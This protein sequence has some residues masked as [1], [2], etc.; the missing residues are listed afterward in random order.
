MPDTRTERIAIENRE[1]W[2]ALRR[3]DV[4]A[5]I[6][7]CLVGAHP[8]ATAYGLWASKTGRIP[9]DVEETAPMRRG[10]LLESVAVQ[11]L[12]EDKPEWNIGQH[13]VGFYYRDP[14]ARIGATPD[15][16]GTDEHGK[17]IVVQIKSVEASVFRREWQDEDRSITPPMWIVVQ[18]IIEASLTGAERAFVAP[19]VVSYGLDMP[20]IEVP[21]HAGIVGRIKTEVAAFWKLVDQ[22]E[23]P[24]PD[25]ARDG[26]IIGR[27]FPRDDGSE[28]D[29]TADNA[30]PMLVDQL[31]EARAEKK[32]A[33]SREDEAKA[34]ILA[35]MGGASYARMADGRRVSCRLQQRAGYSVAPSEFRVTRILNG[36]GR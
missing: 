1:Q 20:V 13:P 22:G 27:I 2:L 25:Y 14:D 5:S 16:L 4:T 36:R 28:I 3:Q 12:R 15:V 32:L 7:A 8:Y 23:A 18:A 34:G 21:L 9:D 33:A 31:A 17:K 30:F 26:D 29:L 35:K 11:L 19:M 6:A 24:D 10:R